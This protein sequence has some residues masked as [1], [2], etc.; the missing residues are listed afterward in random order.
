[1]KEYG[2]DIELLQTKVKRSCNCKE[3]RGKKI[4]LEKV[5][6]IDS[7]PFDN[8]NIALLNYFRRRDFVCPSFAYYGHVNGLGYFVGP[9]EVKM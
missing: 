1:M 2:F 7:I 3:I 6:D 8:W 4:I 5:V 9:D